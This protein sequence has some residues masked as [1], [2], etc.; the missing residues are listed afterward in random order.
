K[1]SSWPSFGHSTERAVVDRFAAALVEGAKGDST[2]SEQRYAMQQFLGGFLHGNATNDPGDYLRNLAESD[3][4]FNVDRLTAARKYLEENLKVPPAHLRDPVTVFRRAQRD[5]GIDSFLAQVV[6]GA[7]G[8]GSSIECRV[9]SSPAVEDWAGSQL[10]TLRGH[11]QSYHPVSA[12]PRTL[13]QALR[14]EGEILTA[15]VVV[16]VRK[17]QDKTGATQPL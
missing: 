8:E 3:E 15:V 2:T 14:D 7:D 1:W 11:V 10:M 13:R 4:T 16:F 6:L 9:I 5:T 17:P 12:P